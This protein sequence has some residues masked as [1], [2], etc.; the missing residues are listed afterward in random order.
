MLKWNKKCS[1]KNNSYLLK[2]NEH[3]EIH[4]LL[5]CKNHIM[6]ISKT[7]YTKYKKQK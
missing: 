1:S 6:Q 7:K 4:V 3:S 2:R 5:E